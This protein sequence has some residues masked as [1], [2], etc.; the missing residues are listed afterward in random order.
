MKT[1]KPGLWFPC[2]NY[3]KRGIPNS[4]I[5]TS[6]WSRSNWQPRVKPRVKKWATYIRVAG[7]CFL[8]YVLP[9]PL[10]P[11]LSHPPLGRAMPKLIHGNSGPCPTCMYVRFCREDRQK[12]GTGRC[13][14]CDNGGNCNHSNKVQLGVTMAT[15][16]LQISY[17][18]RSL[19]F[20]SKIC[21][22]NIWWICEYKTSRVTCVYMC[23]MYVLCVLC[24]CTY[25]CAVGV[26]IFVCV[27]PCICFVCYMWV[28]VLCVCVVCVHMHAYMCVWGVSTCPWQC[29]HAW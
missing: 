28:H 3:K 24:L 9:F 21:W 29:M 27:C 18:T 7:C 14:H 10:L 1:I 23:Y 15:M 25:K 5:K 19:V 2:Y 12:Q 6:W 13:N 22:P 20:V 17:L 4:V 11:G 16:C 8:S 26:C